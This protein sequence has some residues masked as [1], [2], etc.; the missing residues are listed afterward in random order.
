MKTIK[1]YENTK[2]IK[3]NKNIKVNIQ[4]NEK[5]SYK[6]QFGSLFQ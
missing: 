1:V 4:N 2:N 5:K 3:R 6:K